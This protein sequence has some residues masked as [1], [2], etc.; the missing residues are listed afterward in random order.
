MLVD[1]IIWLFVYLAACGIIGLAIG[2]WRGLPLHGAYYGLWFGLLSEVL[3]PPL[4]LFF[5]YPA[6]G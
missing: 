6:G 5:G 3:V 4:L 2:H 1:L